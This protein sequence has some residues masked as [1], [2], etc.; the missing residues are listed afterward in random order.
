M[1]RIALM[2]GL[3][4]CLGLPASALAREQLLGAGAW[5]YHSDPRAVHHRGITY[6]GWITTNGHVRVAAIDHATGRVVRR[7]IMRGLGA[8]DHHYPVFHVRSD[9]RIMAFYSTHSGKYLPT[10][11]PSRMYY[12]TTTRPRDIRSWSPTRTIPTNTPGGWGHTYPNA[13]RAAG[14]LWLFWR[15]GNWWPTFVT[16]TDG[17]RSWSRARN[18][19][20]GPVGN[21][22]YIK[23]AGRGRTIHMAYTKD[24]PD[25]ARTSLYYAQWRNGRLY[26]AGGRRLGRRPLR[27]DRGELIYGY[28]RSLGRGWVYDIATDRAGR[29]VILYITGYDRREPVFWYA[30]WTGSEWKKTRIVSAG[31]QSR[32]RYITGGGTLDHDD[33]STVYLSRAV[34]G[35][36]QVEVWHTEDDGQA[37]ASGAVTSGSVPSFRPVSPRGLT[38][39]PFV[40]YLSGRYR[41]WL[42]YRQVRVRLTDQAPFYAPLP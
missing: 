8:D 5:L 33:P 40:I 13:V 3:A 20:V 24:T 27:Y 18:M 21:K 36:S 14:K 17:G 7:T 25:A 32:Q 39:S 41:G 35:I 29:P 31:R 23:Y 37:W 2:A 1:R 6:T 30:K 12:R 28:R 16:S 38:D 22:P 19:I 10:D 4:C 9:G 26:G 42:S 15:G 34:D 11:R